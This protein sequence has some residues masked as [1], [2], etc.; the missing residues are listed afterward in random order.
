M[1]EDMEDFLTFATH[2]GKGYASVDEFQKR[3]RIFKNNHNWVE[4][5][6]RKQENKGPDA[7]RFADNF[8]SDW[9]DSEYRNYKGLDSSRHRKDDDSDEPDLLGAVS[10]EQGGLGF[11]NEEKIDWVAAGVM[12]P[13]KD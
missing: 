1:R 12:T 7:A 5:M 4:R 6:N 13:V 3:Q 2:N 9:E 8:F 11:S 10:Y